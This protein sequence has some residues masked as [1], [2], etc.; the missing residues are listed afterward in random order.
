MHAIKHKIKA[1]WSDVTLKSCDF[2]YESINNL[3]I[4]VLGQ[5]SRL[6][7]YVAENGPNY[8]EFCKNV[9]CIHELSLDISKTAVLRYIRNYFT[10]GPQYSDLGLKAKKDLIDNGR[11]VVPTNPD[12]INIDD[13]DGDNGESPTSS[14]G[15]E[16]KVA[17]K[18]KK[19]RKVKKDKATGKEQ[20]EQEKDPKYSDGSADKKE[21]KPDSNN[22]K[23]GQKLGD[24]TDVNHNDKNV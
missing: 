9:C 18:Q 22:G 12:V 23:D 16:A 7:S 24:P 14:K 4:L 10:T 1:R 5:F 15:A 11:S 3:D 17:K 19:K 13:S 21:V 6:T 2:Y 20:K 8:S